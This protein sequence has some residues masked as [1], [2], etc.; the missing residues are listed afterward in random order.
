MK[1]GGGWERGAGK[2]DW[3]TA[4][5]VI[6]GKSLDDQDVSLRMVALEVVA[7]PQLFF[8]VKYLE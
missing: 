6:E 4:G 3:D 7:L 2:G 5:L 1:N 8:E